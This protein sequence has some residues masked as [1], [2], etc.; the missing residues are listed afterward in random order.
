MGTR[1]DRKPKHQ[2]REPSSPAVPG[3][4]THA[5]V[6]ILALFWLVALIVAGLIIGGGR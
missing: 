5:G 6:L 4:Q 3:R 1:H 2:H